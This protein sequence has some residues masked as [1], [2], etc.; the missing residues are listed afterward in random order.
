MSSY[1]YD[2]RIA[3]VAR[4][5]ALVV[6]VALCATAAY[7]AGVHPA[8]A[9]A[10]AS[11][12]AGGKKPS[13]PKCAKKPKKGKK[14]CRPRPGGR[15]PS[16]VTQTT[17][18]PVTGTTVTPVVPVTPE[19]VTPDPPVITQEPPPIEVPPLGVGDPPP[20]DGTPANEPPTATDNG[21]SS[22]DGTR[23]PE[24][25]DAQCDV[26]APGHP[27]PA[28]GIE[29]PHEEPGRDEP[30]TLDPD[31]PGTGGGADQFL[32]WTNGVV[33]G[34]NQGND[35][36]P[37]HNTTYTRYGWDFALGYGEAVR[38]GIRGL[39]VSSVNGC[40]ATRS[41]GCNYGWGNSV[42]IR[43]ADGTCARFGHLINTTVGVGAT[44]PRYAVVGF[45]G[46]SGNS[47]GTH[48][49]YQREQCGS[50]ASIPSAFVEAGIPRAGQALRSANGDEAPGPPQTSN[51]R[52]YANNPNTVG[53]GGSVTTEVMLHYDGPVDVPCAHARLGSVGDV[54]IPWADRSKPDFPDGTWWMSARR[55]IPHDCY[56]DLHP[57]QDAHYSVTF[58]VP[59]DAA[60]GIQR[61]ARVAF[62]H[63]GRAWAPQQFDLLL[64]VKP[65]MH[66]TLVDKSITGSIKPG[67]QGRLT[68]AL[69]NDG[70][71]PWTRGQFNLGTASPRDSRFEYADESW[72]GGGNRVQLREDSVPV[73]EVGHF[74]AT[75]R[76][77]RTA[78]AGC[79]ELDLSPV[80]EGRYWLGGADLSLQACVDTDWPVPPAGTPD[81]RAD[82]VGQDTPRLVEPATEGK[83]KFVVKNTGRTT[84]DKNVHLGS[85]RTQ[86]APIRYAADGVIG[87]NRVAFSDEDGDGLVAYGEKA[88]FEYTI[89]P[90]EGASAAYR[91]YLALVNDGAGPWFFKEA[92]MY[93]PVVVASSSH[94]PSEVRSE[95]CTYQLVG[96][97]EPQP[98][99]DGEPARFTWTLKNTS[100]LCP[101]FREGTRPFRLGTQRPQDASSPFY[102]GG[103]PAWMSSR[104][105]IQMQEAVVPPGGTATFT[106]TV[107]KPQGMAPNADARLYADPVVDGFAWLRSI[108]MYAPIRVR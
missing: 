64:D 82:Y 10:L 53:A 4:L 35:S 33:H 68:V 25:V 14:K 84:W 104:N 95:D 83:F 96:Q 26:D 34:V 8:G 74:E 57:G 39:V 46:S 100:D 77:P 58:R 27:A 13:N 20:P 94:F 103:D 50:Q 6:A 5:V 59:E 98:I 3:R 102:T 70:Q 54:D 88:T 79:R 78:T 41:A 21:D 92:G 60:P 80:W 61:A 106:F 85:D 76:P 7:D 49:H 38:T 22:D 18:T 23:T 66:A 28:C 55:V 56:G 32:P 40:N 1:P 2:I 72:T 108:G 29:P 97:S 12:K 45:A 42:V 69:R 65:A 81:W 71:L 86:D 87:Q 91:Q 30:A 9:T 62:V 105:R 63:E 107:T 89:R 43:V 90:P 11:A 93:A 15:E 75:Y 99:A 36:Y 24:S 17:P 51:V 44:V 31:E 101:W 67:T 52:I 47:S 73:G 37:S 19:P 48:L 16:Q